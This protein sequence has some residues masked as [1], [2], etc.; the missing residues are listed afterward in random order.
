MKTILVDGKVCHLDEAT[1]EAVEPIRQIQR[2]LLD[3]EVF[4]HLT[5]EEEDTVDSLDHSLA[6]FIDCLIEGYDS[7]PG[8]L[9]EHASEF[10]NSFA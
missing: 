9:L 8:G 4:Y 10:I 3:L 2:D 7:N 1:Y 5:E 6:C